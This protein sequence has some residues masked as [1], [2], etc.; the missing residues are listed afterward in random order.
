M[1]FFKLRTPSKYGRKLAGIVKTT[2]VLLI[3]GF[4]VSVG[5]LGITLYQSVYNNVS[6]NVSNPP[7]GNAFKGSSHF[8]VTPIKHLSRLDIE[9][10][11]VLEFI[12][13]NHGKYNII[14]ALINLAGVFQ[15]LRIFRI[16]DEFASFSFSIAK[17][18]KILGQIYIVGFV[19]EL[20]RIVYSVFTIR[21]LTHGIYK[22]EML[23]ASNYFS[24]FF[25]GLILLV[26]AA[27]YKKACY[28]Q[29]EQELTV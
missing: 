18:I 27:I 11:N 7:V 10:P 19:L 12:F 13:F 24:S 23:S 4:I 15:L 1:N 5:S 20:F 3:L 17:N 26:V 25:A 29:E 28:L 9:K 2:Y 22:F 14:T 8:K 6:V 21:H 16:L